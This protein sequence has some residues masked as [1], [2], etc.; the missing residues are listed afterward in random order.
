MKPIKPTI[1]PLFVLKGQ[2]VN[3]V[4]KND[5]KKVLKSKNNRDKKELFASSPDN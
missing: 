2:R 4:L 5:R 1:L 3:I